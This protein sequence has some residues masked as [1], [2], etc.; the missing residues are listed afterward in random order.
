MVVLVSSCLVSAFNETSPFVLGVPDRIVNNETELRDAVNNAPSKM[1]III[2]LNND[3]SLS[4]ALIISANTDVTLTSNKVDRFYKLI[5]ANGESTI[6]VEEDS[7]LR[8]V[9]IIVTHNGSGFGQ[10]VTVNSG[11]MFIMSG[12]EISGNSVGIAHGG[13]GV[14]V[15]GN[16]VFNL[17]GGKVSNNTA[18]VGGGAYVD[19]VFVMS[20]GEISGNTAVYAGGGV[21]VNYGSFSLSGGEVFGNTVSNN[22]GGLYNAYGTLNLSD[23]EVFGN[24]A[25]NDGGGVHNAFG[26]L[27][28]SGCNIYGNIPLDVYT[29]DSSD[30][31]SDGGGLSDEN[32]ESSAGDGGF[33]G[34]DGSFIGNGE[35][36]TGY[37]FSV[38]CVMGI[39]FVVIGV[40]GV[41]FFYF[42]KTEERTV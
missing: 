39:L 15:Y 28:L 42:K 17:V 23:G 18:T 40:V 1:S 24:T 26:T 19:G 5:G 30:S 25:K 38:I 7:V 9:G 12:G 11:G 3:I 35:V 2:A 41:L 13:G 37:G 10:G 21:W 36:S 6:I 31:P 27:N 8:F 29:F 32:S 4:S 33:L 22:G 20:G 16:G 14:R 34:G